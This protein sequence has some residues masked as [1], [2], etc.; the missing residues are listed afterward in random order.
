[1]HRGG[2]PGNDENTAANHGTDAKCSQPPRPQ[3][4]LEAGAAT[5]IGVGEIGFSGK[6]L[7]EHYDI[8]LEGRNTK[9]AHG[10]RLGSDKQLLHSRQFG[11]DVPLAR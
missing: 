3:R 11:L 1:M 7:S 9:P 10:R 2:L 8:S 4:A 6:Q 5:G